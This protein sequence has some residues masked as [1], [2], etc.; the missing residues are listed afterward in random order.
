MLSMGYISINKSRGRVIFHFDGE[1][2]LF[3]CLTAL[4]LIA[5]FATWWCADRWPRCLGRPRLRVQSYGDEE[6]GT[7]NKSHM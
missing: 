5:T 6:A 3:G 2:V 1:L 7:T 4:F